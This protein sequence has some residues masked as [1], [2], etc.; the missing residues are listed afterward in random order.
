MRAGGSRLRLPRVRWGRTPTLMG[1]HAVGAT[2]GKRLAVVGAVAGLVPAIA[3]GGLRV[4]LSEPAE[5][6]A[7][8][9]GNAAFTLA[10]VSPYVLALLASRAADPGVRG[11]L[12]AATAV[13]SLVASLSASYSLVALV[14]WPATLV[15]GL[16]AAMSLTISERTT[17]TA[18]PAAAGGLVI[19]AV[20]ALGLFVVLGGLQDDTVRCWAASSGTEQRLGREVVPATQGPATVTVSAG[21]Y[22][23]S[24]IVT[25]T[26]AALSMGLAAASVL[27]MLGVSR[28]RWAH[29]PRGRGMAAQVDS[30]RRGARR[31]EVH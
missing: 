20:A 22:C 4:L 30:R 18:L 24:D 6:T 28:V 11:G 8:V 21:T 19:A 25:D 9:A 27:G 3:L 31:P 16:S 2:R 5:A 29:T 7:Q 1:P 14:F 23:T 26:E 12:L 10:Y 13:L 17:K 15:L